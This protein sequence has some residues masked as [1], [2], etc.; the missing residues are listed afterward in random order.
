MSNVFFTS[1]QHWF[2]K[3]VTNLRGFGE[4][5]AAVNR[6]N[7]SLIFGWE[8]VVRPDDVVWILGDLTVSNGTLKPALEIL[9]NL[10]GR[11]RL[12]YGNHDPAHP[13]HRDA[14][15][16]FAKYHDVFEY[17][18]AFARIKVAGK[19]VLLSHFPYTLDHTHDARYEQWRLKDEGL[20]L[21]HGHT[22]SVY[23][24]SSSRELHVGVDAWNMA[25]VPLSKVER[26]VT[27]GAPDWEDS[28]VIK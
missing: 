13:M 27:E 16:W 9:S 5:E 7:N 22:H 20:H 25:P 15:K 8:S 26:F 6:H 3:M 11:K 4:G 21:L 2:H 17:H 23:R 12:I 28:L 18:S 10:P 19:P 1:D 24:Y 14:H